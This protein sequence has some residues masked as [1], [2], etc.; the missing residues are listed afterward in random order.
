[1]A[2]VNQSEFGRHFRAG[3]GIYRKAETLI[4]RVQSTVTAANPVDTG[5]SRSSWRIRI[6]SDTTSVT[7]QTYNLVEYVGHISRA[8]SREPGGTFVCEAAQ[9]ALPG[10]TVTCNN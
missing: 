4:T 2:T 8:G 6:E 7:A 9:R 5:R 1:M 3:G 10:V